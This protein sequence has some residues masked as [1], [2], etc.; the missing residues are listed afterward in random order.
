MGT[1]SV[2]LST[3]K[4]G[5]A[6]RARARARCM[7]RA[8]HDCEAE[9]GTEAERSS[10][11]GVGVGVG[12]GVGLGLFGSRGCGHARAMW[13]GRPHRRQLPSAWFISCF[14]VSTW[15]AVSVGAA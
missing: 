12:V 8:V 3:G 9:I 14:K 11:L 4:A 5:G 15:A 6:R 10:C 7:A 2:M 13:P 1:T